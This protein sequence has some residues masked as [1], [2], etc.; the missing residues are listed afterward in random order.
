MTTENHRRVLVVDDDPDIRSLLV[1]ALRLKSL[2]VDSASNGAEAL[3]L[4]R[5]NPYGVV[6]L[7]L[8]MPEIDGFAVLEQLEHDPQQ[9]V[10]LVVTGADRATIERLDARRIHGIVRKPFDIDDLTAVVVSCTDI[11][12]RRN[13]DAVALALISG[14]LVAFLSS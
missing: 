2:L 13:L 4:I 9:P 1:T 7:D 3:E 5:R 10:V 6:L 8:F 12:V 11:R 14:P